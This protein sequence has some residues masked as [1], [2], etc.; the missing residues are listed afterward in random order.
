M[1]DVS[2][3]LLYKCQA[4][5]IS[6][7]EGLLSY[8]AM[9]IPSLGYSPAQMLF[10][11]NI[12]TKLVIKQSQLRPEVPKGLREKMEIRKDKMKDRY[13]VGK[14]DLKP[15]AKGDRVMLQ[16]GKWWEKAKVLEADQERRSY[17]VETDKGKKFRRNRIFLR[18]IEPIVDVEVDIEEQIAEDPGAGLGVRRGSRIRRAPDWWG[19][20]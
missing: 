1:V 20:L 14:R 6:V 5:G 9:P 10:S 18:E 2:K 17:V 13:D 15:L 16:L 4:E 19:G 3:K 11:R 8:R 7:E 12:R